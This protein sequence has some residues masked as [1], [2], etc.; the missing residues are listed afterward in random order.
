MGNPT[1]PP[2]REPFRIVRTPREGT[3]LQPPASTLLGLAPPEPEP[4]PAPPPPRRRTLRPPPL[5]AELIEDARARQVE[6][7]RLELTHFRVKWWPE[8]LAALAGGLGARRPRNFSP[9]AVCA[10]VV[11]G[12]ALGLVSAAAA[13]A[14]PAYGGFVARIAHVSPPPVAGLQLTTC[15]GALQGGRLE[16]FR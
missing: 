15:A 13:L 6:G 1:P 2:P 16:P 9:V 14:W 4:E 3:P 8:Q 10:G 7:L 12:L 5:P 11:L